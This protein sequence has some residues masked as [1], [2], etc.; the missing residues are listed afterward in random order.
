MQR[1]NS[2]DI[3]L[4]DT[5]LSNQVTVTKK[6]EDIQTM[7]GG[8]TDVGVLMTESLAHAKQKPDVIIAITDGYKPWP[9]QKEINCPVLVAL[10]RGDRC[11]QVPGWIKKINI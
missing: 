8:G 11:E 6:L 4:G 9:T 7:G 5:N 1:Q 10:T 3:Y 2:I